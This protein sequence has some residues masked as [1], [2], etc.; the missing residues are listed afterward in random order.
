V[1]S[2]TK[3]KQLVEYSGSL[4]VVDLYINDERYY[5]RGYLAKA[6]FVEVYEL[7]QE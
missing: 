1:N 2:D 6:V 3:K 5:K 7:D 4:Y